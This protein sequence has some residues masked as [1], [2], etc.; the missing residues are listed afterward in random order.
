MSFNPNNP[1]QEPENR[2]IRDQYPGNQNA[3]NQGYGNQGYDNSQSQAQPVNEPP[4]VADRFSG[5]GSET[6]KNKAF[7]SQQNM[8]PNPYN[9]QDN[10]LPYNYSQQHLQPPTAPPI[11]QYYNLTHQNFQQGYPPYNIPPGYPQDFNSPN[12]N[13]YQAYGQPTYPNGYFGDPRYP[14][15]GPN[16]YQGPAIK[17]KIVTELHP[18]K[19][20]AWLIIGII[21]A[22]VGALIGTSVSKS[23]INNNQQTIVKELFPTQSAVSNPGSISAVLAKDLPAVVSIQATGSGVSDAGT[24]MIITPNG[25][26][27]TNNHVIAAASIV[28]VTLYGQTKQLPAKVL[29]AIPSKDM[30]LVQI[31][32]VKNL[33]TLTLGNSAAI[34]QG[35]SVI[36]IG[37]ALALA[38]GPTVTTGIISALNRQLTATNDVTGQP[39]NLSGLIQTDAPINPGNSGG[40]L[41]LSNGDVIGMNTAV[42]GSSAGNAPTQNV[43]FAIPINSVKPELSYLAKGGSTGTPSTSVP[44]SSNTP[45]MGVY[46]ETFSQTLAQQLGENYVPGVLVT[47]VIPGYAA[48]SAGVQTYDVI[49]QINGSSISSTASL[50]S[51]LNKFKPG[52]TVTL[53]IYRSGTYLNIPIT[54]GSTP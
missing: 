25:E 10:R 30:A 53:R 50:R 26:V 11:P 7:N 17:R 3:G 34:Q 54:L 52:N 48:A 12:Y 20:S 44:S 35:D 18:V 37:N 2:N 6:E 33:P 41:V 28:T 42:A 38:G 40:P 15:Y 16:P 32:N 21:A 1:D 46:V 43:G 4:Y 36:A 51:V 45:F 14:N 39:E 9:E 19:V 8:Q 13:P 27:L 22:L 5:Q 24:G 23:L 47:G 49:T 31:L 29:G